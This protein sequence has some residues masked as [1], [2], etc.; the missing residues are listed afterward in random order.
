MSVA[1]LDAMVP[2]SAAHDHGWRTLALAGLAVLAT[3]LDTT[4]LFVAFPDLVRSFPTATAA[5]LSWVLNGYTI[6]FA[7]LLV[8]AGKIADR[9]GHRRA[10]LWGSTIFT[11][12]SLGCA[13]APTPLVLVLVRVLQA[14]GGATLIPASLALVLHAFPRDKV[15]V[16]LAIWGAMGAVAGATGPTLGA[17]LVESGG[18]RWVFLIN[19]PVGF[20]T[21]G[22]G[23][24]FLQE[25]S[26]EH[27]RLPAFAGVVLIAAAAS[28]V[29]LGVV[30]SDDW[31][32]S[33]P[34]TTA[35]LAAGA[36]LLV[37]FVLHQ[38]RSPAPA[39]DLSLFSSANYSWAN[40]ATL[41]FAIGFTAMFFASILFLTQVWQW[42]VLSAGLG[43]SPGPL[44][45]A[46]LAPFTG[47]LAGRVG[48]RPLIVAGGIAF[49]I[50]GGWRLVALGAEPNYV[51]Q[52]LPS[53]L[54]TG[55]GVSL[56]LPQLASIVAQ[57]LPPNRL[58][59]GGGANQAIRQLG[60]TLGVA[61]AIAFVGRPAGGGPEAAA[62]AFDSVWWL[63]VA[64][65][66]VTSVL[67][68]PLRTGR[69]LPEARPAA[70]QIATAAAAPAAV[71]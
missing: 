41:S 6:A 5:D 3:F 11:I 28:L 35:S 47:R 60:G 13:V 71:A 21:V 31:S 66:M 51:T 2:D 67:A 32:W 40:A 38:R 14:V 7:A 29:S 58:G 53:M 49:A 9:V 57:S 25:S 54:F 62:G 12:A 63:L 65:G 59:V 8:P 50:G 44:L 15:P 23:R 26:D 18:W 56:C 42:S 10:F 37:V 22:L 70:E 17:L 55:F 1:S 61:L 43:V 34:K 33:D 20:I 16:A 48:Q 39:L 45:V 68:L 52:Y 19:L 69:R 30:K 46:V 27:S 4:V 24:R 36:I 64:G